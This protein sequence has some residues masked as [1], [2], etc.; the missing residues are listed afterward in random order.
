MNIGDTVPDF[1]LPDQ[2]GKPRDIREFRGQWVVLYFYP[3]DHTPGCTAEACSFRDAYEEFQD[4]GAE[5]IGVSING[6][7]KH[8]SFIAKYGLPFIL[9]TD[10]G[11]KV[12]KTMRVKKMLGLLLDRVTFVIDPEGKIVHRFQSQVDATEHIPEALKA[13]Q[14]PPTG[15][16]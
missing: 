10:K 7:K 12:A 8:Q 2:D 4:L 11:G 3:A 13:I 14:D 9:L 1:S 5:V 6:A 16:A 15:Q